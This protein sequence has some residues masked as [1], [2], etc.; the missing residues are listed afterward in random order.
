MG[1]WQG[2]RQVFAIYYSEIA[3][4]MYDDA[5]TGIVGDAASR[6]RVDERFELGGRISDDIYA[7]LDDLFTTADQ[8]MN[9]RYREI[10]ELVNTTT[11][12]MIL[13]T[14]VGA[15]LGVAVAFVITRMVTKPVNEVVDVLSNVAEGNFNINMKSD[16]PRDE[17]GIMTENV[18]KLI[19]TIRG[20]VDDISKLAHEVVVNGDI[21]YRINANKYN[22]GYNEMMTSLNDFQQATVDDVLG[23]L[24]VLGRVNKGD[25]D[26]TLKQKNEKKQVMNQTMEA[27]LDNLKGVSGE[28][29]GMIN[30]AAVKGE[31]SFKIDAAKYDGGWREIMDGL[32]NVAAAVDAPLREIGGIMGNLSR[33]DFS[34]SVSGNYAGDFLKI[35]NAVNATIKSL[36]EYIS[37]IAETLTRV[38]DGDLTANVTR[39]Y[40]GSFSTIKSSLNNISSSLHKT[41]SEINSASE[42]VL[43]GAKQ[44]S[45]SAMDLANGASSQASS[46]EELNASVDLINQQTRQNADNAAEANT[47]SQTST[48][49]AMEGNEAMQQTLGAMNQIKDA[50]AN[51]SKIIR[52]IQDIAFQTN[53][54]A[55]NAAV[56]AARAGE[57]GRGFAVVAEEVRSL[58]ARSQTAASETTELIGTSIATVDSGSEIAQSTAETLDTIVENA[59]KVLNIVGSIS[60]ASQ[61][62]AEAISQVV[63]GLSQIS[64]VVQSNSAVSEEAAAAAEELN[65]QAEILQ[66]L[67]GFF[68]L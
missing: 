15:V 66:Q 37:E 68:K 26:A 56:E 14:V 40:V 9:N 58:A 8:T 53:L 20:M 7:Y 23:M 67:V 38:A 35:K 62:Q 45:A 29:G 22:G 61:E 12:I 39:E 28:V 52:T 25:Y 18:Y 60:T 36:S 24:Q 54:L 27:L 19:G 30:A 1:N 33:G 31:L 4:G 32:N 17:I 5:R 65:S 21:E 64:Q 43:S 48:S 50:S 57:H 16:I 51:I 47:L 34:T 41:M 59:N 46:V 2:L 44:I 55:L 13:L 11:V 6:A 42:Q 10:E 3:Q 63:Q 49:N